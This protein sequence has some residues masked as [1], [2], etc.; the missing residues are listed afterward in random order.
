[1]SRWLFEA[2]PVRVCATIDRD[3]R[4]GTDRHTSALLQF[5][6]GASAFSCSTQAAPYQR[7]NL[8]GDAGRVEVEI[9][10][11]PPTDRPTRLRWQHA[12]GATEAITLERSNHYAIQGELFSQA[13]LNDTPVPT[14][15][16]DAVAN[17]AVIDAIV[18]S[19]ASGRWEGVA[20]A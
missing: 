16:S 10:F 19:A 1:V 13:I 5:D 17:M 2:E 3:P 4:F 18:R 20:G 12:D 8:L 11:N 6:G 9:P 7:V 14:P 15:L